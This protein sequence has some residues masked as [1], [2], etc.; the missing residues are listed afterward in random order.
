MVVVVVVSGNYFSY[1]YDK[2]HLLRHTLFGCVKFLANAQMPFET[3]PAITVI[4]VFY[5]YFAH[6]QERGYD[7]S[8][9][10]VRLWQA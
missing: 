10:R 1:V 8:F 7:Y 3:L 6:D 2:R 5:F 9:P 4:L